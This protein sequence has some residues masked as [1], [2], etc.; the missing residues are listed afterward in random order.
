MGLFIV[1][2]GVDYSGKTTMI[3]KIKKELIDHNLTVYTT[4]EPGGTKLGD[5]LR[6]K[7]IL[8]QKY[9]IDQKGQALLFLTSR[10]QHLHEIIIPSLKKY[11]IVLCD[12]Y[13]YSTFVYQ[14]LYN[15]QENWDLIF[16]LHQK[17]K[18]F[19]HLPNLIVFLKE[20]PKTLMKRKQKYWSLKSFLTINHYDQRGKDQKYFEK[21]ND[22]YE[23][24]FQKLNVSEQKLIRVEKNDTSKVI[25]KI[26]TLCKKK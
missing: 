17:L 16:S 9:H 12:R 18:I 13:F 25:Q 14:G 20:N 4:F 8:N 1:L 11:D 3:K 19:E 22:L 2:E 5:H 24:T 10:Y 7:I 23:K 21:M 26:L 15:N 6:N